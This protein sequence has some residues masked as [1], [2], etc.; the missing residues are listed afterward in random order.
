VQALRGRAAGIAKD[1]WTRTREGASRARTVTSDTVRIVS[2]N[3]K[4]EVAQ[5]VEQLSKVRSPGEAVSVLDEEISRILKMV[6][7]AFVANPVPI[8]DARV[9]RAVVLLVAASAAGAEEIEEL[10]L[11]FS[12][13]ISAPGLVTVLAFVLLALLV[14]VGVATSL[15]V[16]SM[17][18]AGLEPDPDV[19]AR[20]V[21]SAMLGSGPPGRRWMVTAALRNPASRK[22][23]SRWAGGLVPV[24]GVVYSAWDAQGTIAAIAAMPITETGPAPALPPGTAPAVGH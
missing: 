5:S 8:R 12:S 22:V 11:L 13:G 7:P 10:S 15:R 18:D 14:E 9:A 1:S 20:D 3:A 21:Q 6:V 4:P 23:L 16:N 19:V 2:E 24:A 17:R